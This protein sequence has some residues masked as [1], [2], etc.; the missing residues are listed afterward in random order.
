VVNAP[1]RPGKLALG[2]LFV[3]ILLDFVGFS[4]LIPV[5]PIHLEKLGAD[6]VDIGLVLALYV[7]ALVIFL[8]FW[9]WISDRIGRRPVLLVCLVGTSVSFAMM[10]LDTELWVFYVARALGGF[11]GA[12]VGTAQAYVIDITAD[13]DRTRGLG[14][15]SA[16]GA[17]GLV[18]GPALGGL[19]AEWG[20]LAPF[21]TPAAFAL[22]AAVGAAFFLPESRS[23]R[24]PPR[25]DALSLV[26]ALVPTPVLIFFKVHDNRTRAYLYLFFHVFAAFAVLEGMFPLFAERRFGWLQWETGLYL[27]FV[28]VVTVLTQGVLIGFFARLAGDGPLVVAG[29]AAA[30]VGMA[31]ISQAH[32]VPVLYVAGFLVA[33]GMGIVLPAFT[34]LFSKNCGTA[35]EAGEYLAHSQAMVQTGRGLGVIWG[36]LAFKYLPLGSP[37][38]L[39]GA[40]LAGALVLVALGLP[41]YLKRR[42]P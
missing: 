21:Y 11:F 38:L 13:E 42:L 9:G 16:A 37:F 18:V 23:E 35:S 22:V 15:V 17:A 19:L 8:P 24:H 3:T 30:A 5:L 26:R 29:L 25:L 7:I 10:A 36:G 41:L 34:S 14:L 32:S 27:S 28:A 12:S 31:G 39:G 33:G 4:I 40:G 20:P 1:G 2:V 6:P